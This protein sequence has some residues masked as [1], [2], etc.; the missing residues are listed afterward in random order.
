MSETKRIHFVT[1]VKDY[2]FGYE[3]KRCG[4]RT[5]FKVYMKEHRD[6]LLSPCFRERLKQRLLE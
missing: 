4:Y 3:C 5:A 1:D 2:G 6:G